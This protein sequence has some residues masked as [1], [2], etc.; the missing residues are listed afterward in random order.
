MDRNKR[1]ITILSLLALKQKKRRCLVL[2]IYKNRRVRGAL[3]NLIEEMGLSD[4]E[5]YF[6]FLRMT[7]IQFNHL[8]TLVGP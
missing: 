4:T 7:P 3:D 2:E 1:S 5:S 6:N 8:L